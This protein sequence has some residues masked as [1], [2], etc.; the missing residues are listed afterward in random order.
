MGNSGVS[1]IVAIGEVHL[2]SKLGKVIVLNNVR[3]IPDFLLSLISSGKLDDKGYINTFSNGQSD[4]NKGDIVIAQWKKSGTLCRAS[5][6]ICKGELNAI[7]T[8]LK[9]WYDRLCHMS[10]KGLNILSKKGSIPAFKESDLENCTHYLMGKHHRATFN[11]TSTRK[12]GV[13]ELVYSDVRGPMRL[14]TLAG[15]SYFVTF[16]NDYSRKVWCYAIKFKD[17]VFSHFKAFHVLV[18]RQTGKPSKCIRTDNGDQNISSVK[19][20][21]VT[22]DHNDDLVDWNSDDDLTEWPGIALQENA[23]TDLNGDKQDDEIDTEINLDI[24]PADAEDGDPDLQDGANTSVNRPF[25]KISSRNR[26]LSTRYP[27]NENILLSDGRELLYYHKAMEREDKNK[28]MQAMQEEMT[29]LYKNNTYSLVKRVPGKKVLQ[30]KWLDVKT[31]F[32]YGDLEEV[33]QM[34]QSEG[35]V[36]KGKEGLVCRLNKS[37]Y[38][39][40]QAPRQ[41]YK[42]F[43]TFMID[44]GFKK[45]LVDHYVYC[46]SFNNESF[47]ILLLYVDDMLLVGDDVRKINGLK[48]DLNRAFEMK[49]IGE[50]THILG[51]QIKRDRTRRHLWLSQEDYILKV[52]RRLNMDTAKPVTC[53]LNA[54]VKLSPKNSPTSQKD[55]EYM[56]NVG[57]ALGVVSRFLSN[58]GK[59]HWKGVKWIL[60]CYKGGNAFAIREEMDI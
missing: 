57:Y 10:V 36:M 23:N 13:L 56:S 51:M 52:L 34:E 11:K 54:Y 29:S 20:K 41:W 17:Q 43:H 22:E 37:L 21:A 30:N 1:K 40:K 14:N 3:H 50:T 6:N 39:L 8:S 19:N 58:P 26:V 47:I 42:K 18:E 48:N 9:L 45:T 27:A 24:Q 12:K 5:F 15:N 35:F 16:I 44:Q 59:E 4:L 31:A 2:K 38:G 53:Q 32:L 55:I 33:I 60:R 28:W 49:D 7:Q 46:K 25:L